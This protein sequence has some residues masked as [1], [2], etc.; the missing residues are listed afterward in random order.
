MIFS[1]TWLVYKQP[2]GFDTT[3][4]KFVNV[5]DDLTQRFFFNVTNFAQETGLGEPIA[6]SM[7]YVGNTTSTNS[8]NSTSSG[9]GTSTAPKPSGAATSGAVPIWAAEYNP[10]IVVLGAFY[11][12]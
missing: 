11:L 12:W 10:F 2:D 9:N 5:T 4:L 8:T 6:G 3:A 1:Y 7:V